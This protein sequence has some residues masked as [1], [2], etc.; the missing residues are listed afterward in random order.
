M[1]KINIT[2]NPISEIYTIVPEE[3]KNADTNIKYINKEKNGKIIINGFFS[4]LIKIRDELLDNEIEKLG[5]ESFNIKFD[6]RSN[7][8]KY[9]ENYPYCDKPIIFKK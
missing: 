6:C 8:N 5:R 7:I 2:K 1:T 3:K 4:F 9:S